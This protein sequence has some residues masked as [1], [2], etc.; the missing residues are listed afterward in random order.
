MDQGPVQVGQVGLNG[1][2][3][4]IEYAA[5]GCGANQFKDGKEH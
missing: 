1:D 2:R 5:A 4:F 3:L